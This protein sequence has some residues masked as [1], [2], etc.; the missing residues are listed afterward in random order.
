MSTARALPLCVLLLALFAG[1]LFAV[2]EQVQEYGLAPEPESVATAKTKRLKFS[3]L[4]PLPVDVRGAFAGIQGT[5]LIVA[6]G[7]GEA[8]VY[9][10]QTGADEWQK[11]GELEA[12][13]KS[14]ASASIDEGLV[15]IGGLRDGTPSAKVKVLDVRGGTL[16]IRSLPDL[17]KPVARPT[18]AVLDGKIYVAGGEDA[19][20]TPVDLFAV[21]DPK[22]ESA[23]WK[24]LQT[25][26]GKPRAGAAMAASQEM[27]YLVGGDAGGVPLK[28][29]FCYSPFTGWKSI[30]N[31]DRWPIDTASVPFG[32]SHIYLLGGTW[33][34]GTPNL[35]VLVYHTITNTISTVSRLAGQAPAAEPAAVRRDND[36]VLIGGTRALVIEPVPVKTGYIWLDHVVVALYLVG[37]VYMGFFFSRR[38]KSSKDYF[39]G[40]NRIPWWASGMS[41]FATGASAISLMSMPGKSYATNWT[42]FVIS[43]CAVLVLPISL[44][45]LAPLVRRLKISTANEYLERR[46]GLLARM[47]G[48]VIWILTQVAGRMASVMLLPA[49][50][51]SAIT[52]VSVVTCILIMGIVTT[53]Y[54]FFGGLEAVVWTDTVQGFVMLGSIAGCLILVLWKLDIGLGQIWSTALAEGKLHMFD[55]S[56]DLTYPTTIIFFLG[57]AV[58]TLGA[59]GDQNFVQRVQCTPDLRQTKLAVATQLAVAVPINVLLFGLGT[60]LYL[61]YQNHPGDLDPTMKTDGVYPFF[62]AQNLPAGLSGLVV[63][64]LLAATM[65][66][67][68]SSICSVSDLGV[69]DF[70]RRFSKRATD[71][72]CLVLG[73]ILTALVGMAGMGSAIFLAQSKMTSVWDLATLVIALIGSGTLGLFWLGL[74][75]TR[76]NEAGAV[77]GV[78][79]SMGVII[80]L[81]MTSPIT[82]WLYGPIGTLVAFVVG[83]LASLIL[84]GKP[85]PLGG[86]TVY[87]LKD[88][89]EMNS[90]IQ[91]S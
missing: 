77:V 57:S 34:D 28:S 74:L 9:T 27:L 39:R 12:P 86:L 58:G 65:S 11:F 76:A 8:A 46:F 48:S 59:I 55:F 52:G 38:E 3:E 2:D 66:T 61:F 88:P 35:D 91:T 45:F 10:L 75:T 67:I 47:F 81:R 41:L 25:W 31:V 20:G 56:W 37:M 13:V 30:G 69:A 53:I 7:E 89:A 42:Y 90:D 68:S 1:T 32:H 70:Y 78:L 4:P 79:A 44:F 63:A 36:V 18:A 6:G 23:G 82:F 83:Y 71:H 54:T 64:A 72:S 22:N 15:L 40:G 49:I 14:G 26:P 16:K 51:L 62:V 19:A 29:A 85:R 33:E 43:I 87:T 84:P 80:Y 5:T 50:A 21:L 60:A 17:P 24:T 73:R